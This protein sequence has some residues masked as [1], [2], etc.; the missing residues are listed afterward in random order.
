MIYYLIL[1]FLEFSVDNLLNPFSEYEY[2]LGVNILIEIALIIIAYG[3]S[4]I[5][6]WRISLKPYF[7]YILSAVFFLCYYPIVWGCFWIEDTA[8]AVAASIGALLAFNGAI[9]II[10]D[11]AVKPRVR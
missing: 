9:F 4:K 11:K 2:G 7:K 3:A 5:M 8:L 10:V 6:V 1:H